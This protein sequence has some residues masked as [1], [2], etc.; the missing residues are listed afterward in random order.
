MS[1]PIYH[2]NKLVI[3]AEEAERGYKLLD[4]SKNF[5]FVQ[6]VNENIVKAMPTEKPL[7][8]YQIR[9]EALDFLKFLQGKKQFGA[10]WKYLMVLGGLQNI[11]ITHAAD[12]INFEKMVECSWDEVLP[13]IKDMIEH[14]KALFLQ[15]PKPVNAECKS[16]RKYHVKEIT[17]G[18]FQILPIPATG[19]SAVKFH[20]EIKKIA[21]E[22]F[23][24]G[25]ALD[26][27]CGS[28]ELIFQHHKPEVNKD[29]IDRIL[30]IWEERQSLKNVVPADLSS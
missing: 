6:P 8:N 19:E 10:P 29:R 5:A 17:P 9:I 21:K 16:K 1:N 18:R 24:V 30:E 23:R 7:K 15:N 26:S 3:T 12:A 28:F 14:N 11:S 13:P 25:A 4:G 2:N 20:A 27:I 22:L